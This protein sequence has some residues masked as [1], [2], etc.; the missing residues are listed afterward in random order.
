[1]PC[2]WYH[3]RTGDRVAQEERRTTN[4]NQGIQTGMNSQSSG[5][6]RNH[7]EVS[8]L[9]EVGTQY[10]SCLL[11]QQ[12]SMQCYVA[13]IESSYPLIFRLS[14]VPHQLCMYQP[15]LISLNR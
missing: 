9:R 3:G 10:S 12:Y 15:T 1:M 4:E 2:A 5:G 11:K 7:L 14:G 13:Y 8:V 6:G